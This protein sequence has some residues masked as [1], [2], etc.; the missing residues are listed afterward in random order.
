MKKDILIF[1]SWL[2]VDTNVGIFFREQAALISDDYNPILVVF[3]PSTL[4]KKKFDFYNH[5]QIIETET[6]DNLTVFEVYFAQKEILGR[7]INQYFEELALQKLQSYLANKEISAVLVHAH[8]LFDAGI[9]AYRYSS[10]FGTPFINTEHQQLSFLNIPIYKS[11]LAIRSLKAAAINLVVSNDKIRQFAANGLFFDFKNIGNLISK[12]FFINKEIAKSDKLRFIT[13]GAF[14]VIK[15]QKTILEALAIVDKQIKEQI[16]FVWIGQNSWGTENDE[17]VQKFLSKYK[18]TN[19]KVVLEPLLDR[20]QISIYLNSAHLFLFS[21]LSE[22]MPVSVL[23]ALGC[24]LPVFT[25]NCGGVDEVI[26]AQNGKIFQIKDYQ[27][28]A[29]LII[30]FTT[31][32]NNYDAD[33]ISKTI[34]EKYGETAFRKKLLSYYA[35]VEN[36]R[37]N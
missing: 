20:N 1:C 28:L 11:Q 5:T 18:F 31:Q 33:T 26:T 12:N 16:E 7:K 23:E 37:V 22:G 21:S 34:L 19:I 8:S 29:K 36:S 24:G 35:Q 25:S 27:T 6:L 9:W 30:G 32:E 2:D 3:K 4:S 14:S 17:T 10:M 13:I 15:D